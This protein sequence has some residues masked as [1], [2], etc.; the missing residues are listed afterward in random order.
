MLDKVLCDNAKMV[1]NNFQGRKVAIYLWILNG[2][3]IT[4]CVL[5]NN[6]P[7]ETH[8]ERIHNELGDPIAWGFSV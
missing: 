2:E 1:S 3:N 4:G 6:I 8:T 7:S 5:E